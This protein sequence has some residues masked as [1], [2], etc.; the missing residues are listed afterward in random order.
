MSFV[1]TPRVTIFHDAAT[2]ARVVAARL[3]TAL[4]QKPSL[5]LGLPTGKT[6][7]AL[8]K[9]LARLT[10]SRGLDWSGATTFNLDEFIGLSA[11]HPGSYRRFMEEHL[12]AFTNLRPERINFLNGM[13]DPAA[14]CR[15][16]EDAIGAAGGIDLQVLGIGT[17]GH[18]GFNEPGRELQ[19]RTHRVALTESTR[20]SN[21]ALFGGD[22]AAVPREALSMGMAT[23]LQARS[24]IL[25]ANGRTKAS[26]IER[27][28]HGPL[29]TDLPASFLQ[30]H[31]DVEIMLDEAAAE[32]L[33]DRVALTRPH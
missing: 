29:S 3:A 7:V 22:V 25:M 9:D 24:V 14:E 16:Y 2:A 11:A 5:V 32:Q 21:A 31:H 27:V 8:Y 6:P 12:F 13:A 30:L 10:A 26:C 15:R 20:R 18:I 19:S 28:V 4:Q 17:N 1:G 23:I 33:T